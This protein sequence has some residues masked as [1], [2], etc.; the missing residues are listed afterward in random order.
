VLSNPEES[1]ENDLFRTKLLDFLKIKEL[2]EIA[3]S[4]VRSLLMLFHIEES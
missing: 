2:G 1:N 3:L 4:K